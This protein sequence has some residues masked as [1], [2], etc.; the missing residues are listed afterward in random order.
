M[1]CKII[2]E[3]VQFYIQTF[4][5]KT[6]AAEWL[7][8]WKEYSVFVHNNAAFTK[9]TLLEFIKTFY[10]YTIKIDDPN[11]II[12]SFTL[13]GERRANILLTYTM[14]DLNKRPI[15]VSQY[16]LLAYSNNKEFWIHTSIINTPSLPSYTIINNQ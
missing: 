14:L 2:N 3:F 8:M 12:M 13:N 7:S 5:D 6:R 9:E 1:D 4:N 10:L 11:D 15:T 16:L